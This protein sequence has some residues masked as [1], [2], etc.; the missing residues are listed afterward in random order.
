MR[1]SI[2]FVVKHIRVAPIDIYLGEKLDIDMSL[3]NPKLRH[4]DVI[5]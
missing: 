3:Q 2:F 5:I 1:S 4:D